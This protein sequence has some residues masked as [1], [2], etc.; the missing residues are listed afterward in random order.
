M[1]R[2]ILSFVAVL[3]GAVERRNVDLTIIAHPG[4]A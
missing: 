3:P 4:R 1:T 2:T